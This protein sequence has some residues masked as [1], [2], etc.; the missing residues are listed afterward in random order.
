MMVVVF[1]V[2]VPMVSMMVVVSMMVFMMVMAM[3]FTMVSVMV[4]LVHV[5]VDVQG[6]DVEVGPTVGTM[7]HMMV[8]PM[9]WTARMSTVVAATHSTH[10]SH[11]TL[12]EC[13]K[14]V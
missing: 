1:V 9:F 7:M 14:S 12:T 10:L 13:V 3:V 2:V 6:L 11:T 8:V 5:K 4:V